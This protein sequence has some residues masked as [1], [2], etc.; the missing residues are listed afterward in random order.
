VRF[1][2]DNCM[3]KKLT[4]AMKLLCGDQHQIEHLTER[5]DPDTGDEVWIPAVASD[6]DFIIISADPAITTSKRQREAWQESRLTAFFFGGGFAD[7]GFWIQALEVVRWWPKIIE[8]ARSAR[9]GSGYLLPF[10]GSEPK[11]LYPP[12]AHH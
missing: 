4:M 3:S 9:R 1:F 10:K 8:V 11:P 7:R 2:F 5:F 6:P 12:R